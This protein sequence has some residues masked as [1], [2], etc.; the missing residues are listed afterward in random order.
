MNMSDEC[1]TGLDRCTEDIVFT[2]STPPEWALAPR[3][4]PEKCHYSCA[5]G[6]SVLRVHVMVVMRSD[7]ATMC[8]V[9]SLV[10]GGGGGSP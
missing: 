1:E 4:E 5:F 6:R 8:R 7:E 3:C 2:K 10:G 9:V